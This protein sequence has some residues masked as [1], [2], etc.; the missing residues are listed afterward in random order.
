GPRRNA[1][2]LGAVHVRGDGK[3]PRRE[4]GVLPPRP[5][6]AIGPQ[7]RFLCHLFGPTAVLAEAEGEVDERP[8]PSAHQTLEARRIAAQ[9]SVDISL[10]LGRAHMVPS[11]CDSGSRGSVA[12]MRVVENATR[13]SPRET[14]EMRRESTAEGLGTDD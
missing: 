11:A 13:I 5:Q 3:E 10:I 8:L 7:K 1:P 9:H 4:G 14:Y 12:F 2:E 6:R